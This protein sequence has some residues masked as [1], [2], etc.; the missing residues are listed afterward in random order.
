MKQLKFIN[1]L[2]D[3]LL[4]KRNH[5]YMGMKVIQQNICDNSRYMR[6]NRIYRI[7]HSSSTSQMSLKLNSKSNNIFSKI[8][9]DI[10]YAYLK[11]S[12]YIQVNKKLTQDTNS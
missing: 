8:F 9:V 10:I 7:L 2:N 1:V 4:L 3:N 6:Y 12:L 5:T 11:E